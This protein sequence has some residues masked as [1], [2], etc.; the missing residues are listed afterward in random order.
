MDWTLLYFLLVLFYFGFSFLFLYFGLR[1]KQWHDVTC[2]RGVTPVT[3]T[4]TQSSHKEKAV[5]GLETVDITA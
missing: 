2:N 4:V 3:V 5:E 1:Q